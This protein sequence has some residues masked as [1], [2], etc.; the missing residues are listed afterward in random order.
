[1]HSPQLSNK[2]KL[3]MNTH[4]LLTRAARTTLPFGVVDD[5]QIHQIIETG[6]SG[7]PRRGGLLSMIANQPTTFAICHRK[8]VV[9]IMKITIHLAVLFTFGTLSAA[10]SPPD[11]KTPDSNHRR[12]AEIDKGRK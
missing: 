9:P 12:N 5:G 10:L 8:G 6:V 11:S 1:M 2:K 3:N 4:R 7:P